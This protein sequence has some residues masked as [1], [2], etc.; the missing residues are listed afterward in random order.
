MKQLFVIFAAL[1][2]F[3]CKKE[4]KS[5]SLIQDLAQTSWQKTQILNSLD[6]IAPDTIPNIL[7]A[8]DDCKKDNI[9]GFNAANKTF[10]I[11]EGA[12]KCNIG[13]ADIKDQGLIEELNNGNSL[14]VAGGT[15]N[16][17]WEIESRT[18]S[19][20]RVSYFARNTSNK[21]VKFRVTFT[22]L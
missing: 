7:I 4:N 6:S 8:T 10:Q 22:K 18:S 2:L 12:T 16:E 20:F 5:S 3:S 9:W 19:S 21:M 14:R 15:T 11:F 17:I 1:A 13:D